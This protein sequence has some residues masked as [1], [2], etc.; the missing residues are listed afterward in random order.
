MTATP[1]EVLRED[2]LSG[3]GIAAFTNDAGR[4]VQSMALSPEVQGELLSWAATG[5]VAVEN[6][7][8]KASAGRLFSVGV[9]LLSS[10]GVDRYLHVFDNTSA[11][12]L[13]DTPVLRAFIP[14]GSQVVLEL[15]AIYG[16][17]F[18]NGIVCAISTTLPQYTSPGGNE[19]FFQVGYV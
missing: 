5:S 10:V 16:R 6:I 18:A 19:G 14:A 11:P 17:E 9:I 2:D 1:T 12:S 3:T 13:N 15:Q 8:A 4:A 7:V